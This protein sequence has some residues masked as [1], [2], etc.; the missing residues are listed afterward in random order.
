M[1]KD[2]NKNRQGRASQ[3]ENPPAAAPGMPPRWLRV[4][5][6]VAILWHLLVVFLSPLSVQPASRLVVD[7]AQSPW[8]RWYSDSL[9]V[10]HG[11]HFFGPEP[12]TNQLIRYRILGDAGDVV[13]EGEFPDKQA[14]RPRLF[15][16]RHMM[17]ADQANL[18]PPDIAPDEWLRLTM[19]SYAR[20][21]LRAHDGARAR[22]DL[23]RHTI[24][25]PSQVERGDDP[26]APDLFV[27]VVSVEESAADLEQPLPV[28]AAALPPPGEGEPL[29]I[30]GQ[31]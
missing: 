5:L 23:V 17:L 28:P 18:G 1:A 24:L 27:P 20:Q 22:I 6:S 13:A 9:Y 26:N 16:H 2:R 30:G 4:V 7:I 11:Y 8:V 10:N 25:L 15:Y 31:L 29:P 21:L 19:R 3:G 14:Q 12:P